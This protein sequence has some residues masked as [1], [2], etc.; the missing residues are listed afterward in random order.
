MVKID[1][2]YFEDDLEVELPEPTP[3]ATDEPATDLQ[4]RPLLGDLLDEEVSSEA[5]GTD[6]QSD[7]APVAMDPA[8]DEVTREPAT[9]E[10]TPLAELEAPET[11]EE[12]F[13]SEELEEEDVEEED[14]EDLEEEPSEDSD[15]STRKRSSHG[16]WYWLGGDAL[17]L[18][19]FRKYI[20]V[21]ITIFLMGLIHVTSNYLIIDKR[22]HIDKL[23]TQVKDLTYKHMESVSELTRRSIGGNFEQQLQAM[24]SDLE[25][26]SQQSII[27]Y[28]DDKK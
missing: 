20:P 5:V 8:D 19:A 27:L 7:F 6:T 2:T 22:R 3:V 17:E 18:P 16:L 24:G 11:P 1:D 28:R 9:L 21:F 26:P 15:Q 23:E 10:S 13:A 25:A 14:E 4:P 12:L